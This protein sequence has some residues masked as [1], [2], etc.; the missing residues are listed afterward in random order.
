M[1]IKFRSRIVGTVGTF[2]LLWSC[3]LTGWSAP[4]NHADNP[5]RRGSDPNW[6]AI[7]SRSGA[8]GYSFN[9]RSRDAAERA[10]RAQCDRAAGRAG[11]CDVRAFFD[12]SCG[13][14]AA[15]NY[16]EWGTAIAPT[17]AAAGSAAVA[18]CNNHLP[19]EP[20]KLVVNICSPR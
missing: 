13:A 19:T 15:G 18:Q 2:A 17:A 3:S 7:A 16:G 6:G 1:K 14:L 9:H 4:S 10:A 8:Y 11:A 5:Q 12:R 20:C